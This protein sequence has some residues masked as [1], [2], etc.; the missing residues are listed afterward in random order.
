MNISTRGYAHFGHLGLSQEIPFPEDSLRQ[1]RKG[2]G[3]TG[4]ECSQVSCL[5]SSV[6]KSI[7]WKAD[8]HGHLTLEK[9]W[10]ILYLIGMCRTFAWH[11]SCM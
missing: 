1:P 6:G 11:L 7:A 9:K 10:N 8:G 4:H 3:S 2:C 5:G